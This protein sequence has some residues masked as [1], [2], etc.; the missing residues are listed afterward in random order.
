MAVGRPR[1]GKAQAL[2]VL[3]QSLGERSAQRTRSLGEEACCGQEPGARR[4]VRKAG[5]GE[6][7]MCSAA[8]REHAKSPT[9]PTPSTRAHKASGENSLRASAA[10]PPLELLPGTQVSERTRTS[11]AELSPLCWKTN[12]RCLAKMTAADAAFS[13][14]LSSESEPSET[15]T[16]FPIFESLVK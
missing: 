12:Q 3:A 2:D 1:E 8:E 5:E 15:H 14:E 10:T 4:T 16:H 13:N 9:F 6:T 7:E 11:A